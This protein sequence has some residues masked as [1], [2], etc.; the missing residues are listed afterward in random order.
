M[1][2]SVLVFLKFNVSAFEDIELILTRFTLLS[3]RN[4]ALLVTRLYSLSQS[5]SLRSEAGVFIEHM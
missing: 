5:I 3:D 2:G 1:F 4:F